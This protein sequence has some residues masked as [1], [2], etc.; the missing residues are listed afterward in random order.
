[1]ALIPL[2]LVTELEAGFAPENLSRQ[3]LG[4]ILAENS[5]NEPEADYSKAVSIRINAAGNDCAQVIQ[6]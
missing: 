2:L 6:L 3:T 4:K 1:M 5:D